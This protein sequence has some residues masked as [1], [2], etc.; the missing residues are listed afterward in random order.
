MRA[1]ATLL[2]AVVSAAV[3][4][5]ADA[6]SLFKLRGLK[7]A[8]IAQVPAS[9]APASSA[10]PLMAPPAELEPGM[11]VKDSTGA[12][13]GT[14]SGI[15]RAADGSSMAVLDVDGQQIVVPAS[16]L[17][18]GQNGQALSNQTKAQLLAASAH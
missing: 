6:S 17:G 13:V 3:A 18:T 10:P 1:L 14:I 12:I 16:S 4:A 15:G 8:K 11:P 2:I 9:S 5:S 7:T